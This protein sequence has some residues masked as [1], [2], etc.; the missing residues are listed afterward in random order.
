MPKRKRTASED[1]NYRL[2]LACP[3]TMANLGCLQGLLSP[4]T[5]AARPSSPNRT[6][7]GS[8]ALNE[9]EKLESYRIYVCIER[10]LPVLLQ[11]HFNYVILK[12]RNPEVTPSP[13]A[14][15]VVLRRM[16][17]EQLNERDD[18]SLLVPWLLPCG[19]V[20]LA[21]RVEATPLITQKSELLLIRYIDLSS[22]EGTDA[23]TR[24]MLG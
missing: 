3:L 21:E 24:H 11:R 16:L 10:K 4:A 1:Y 22:R 8:T 12:Q 15:R 5:M 7:I 13:N 2:L 17:V 19:Q 20:N 9:R 14:K 23:K 18:S 6:T